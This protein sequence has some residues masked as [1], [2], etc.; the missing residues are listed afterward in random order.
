MFSPVRKAC[1]SSPGHLISSFKRHVP[2]ITEPHTRLAKP[3]LRWCP[4]AQVHAVSRSRAVCRSSRLFL[5]SAAL[6]A[7]VWFWR[8]TPPRAP[9]PPTPRASSLRAVRA[10]LGPRSILGPAAPLVG[11]PCHFTQAPVSAGS[12]WRVLKRPL[13]LSG[14]GDGSSLP[15]ILWELAV[16]SSD[17]HLPS[18]CRA[19]CGAACPWFQLA[20]R[21]DY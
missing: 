4:L 11:T 20:L 7:P 5:S 14:A 8:Q 19:S 6:G 12:A 17:S 18:A 21:P 1:K 16:P 3:R 9:G 13:L 15:I 10:I 2:G